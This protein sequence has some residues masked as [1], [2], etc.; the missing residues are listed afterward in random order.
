MIKWMAYTLAALILSLTVTLTFGLQQSS[1]PANPSRHVLLYDGMQVT[2][3]RDSFGVPHVFAPSAAGAFYGGGY[4]VAEDRL[5]QLERFRRDARGEVAEMEGGA[6]V[7]RDREARLTGYTEDE[8]NTAFDKMSTSAKLAC[9]AY[10]AG[11]NTFIE[12]TVAQRRVPA[13]FTA[14]GITRPRLW[15]E[16]DT[17]AIVVMMAQR[18]S[19]GDPTELTNARILRWLRQ[20]FGERIAGDIFDDLFWKNDPESLT[21]ITASRAANPKL[22]E[23]S[24]QNSQINWNITGEAERAALQDDIVE[25]ARRFGLPTKWGSYAWA[26]GPRR[27]ASGA[28]ILVGGPQMG[29][30]TP[31]IAHEIHYSAPNF[32]AIGMGFPGVPGVLIGHNGRVAWTMTSG[33]SDD[34]DIF[35]EKTDPLDKTRYQYRGAWRSM[36]RRNEIIRVRGGSDERMEVFHTVHGPVIGAD[37]SQNTAFTRSVSYAGQELSAME[38]ALSLPLAANVNQFAGYVLNVAPNFNFVAADDGG[39][40]GY[41]HVGK[42][43]IRSGRNDSRLPTPGTGEFDWEGSIPASRLPQ[44]ID[45]PSG[46][47]VNWNNKPAT[48]WDNGDRPEWGTISRIHRIINLIEA[49]SPFTFESAAEIA[50]D[51]STNDPNADYLKPVL[52]ELARKHKGPLEARAERALRYLEAWDNHGVEGSIAKSIFDEWYRAVRDEI[53]GPEFRAIGEEQPG[54]GAPD[55]FESAFRPSVVLRVLR[56]AASS[57]RLKYDYLKGRTREDVAYTSLLKAVQNLN[58][59]YGSQ[60]EH[61]TYSRGTIS[62]VGLPSIPSSNRGTYIQVVE[63]AAPLFRHVSVLPPGQS[64]DPASP[65]YGDQ[66]E[67]AGYWLFKSMP[68][69]QEQLERQRNPN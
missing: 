42:I 14:A 57:L 38:A 18:F 59:H 49:R 10:A 60:I 37:E 32:Q 48:A 65:H 27:T 36:E 7:A 43:P 28:A 34:V 40:I 30:T 64:E 29:F 22:G 67:M 23:R 55:V 33:A 56:Q 21:T 6:A 35:A 3:I 25:Y 19:A 46:Y 9:R 44:I 1:A 53:F 63:L 5:L 54:T 39:H 51:I 4:A 24:Y 20:T 61:W 2:I 47:L 41:W 11:I 45:P 69:A 50:R 62:F 68:F 26:L 12:E 17:A 8:L 16:T 52:I 15:R 66:R 31:Q 58:Q 13:G